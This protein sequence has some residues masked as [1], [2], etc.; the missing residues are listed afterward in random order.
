MSKV[1]VP[2][3][4][5]LHRDM[6]MG[7]HMDSEHALTRLA[8]YADWMPPMVKGFE[9]KAAERGLAVMKES[10]PNDHVER[11]REK[12]FRL[13]DGSMASHALV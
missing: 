11:V 3:R 12:E 2:R 6:L 7:I 8:Q 5:N 9:T 1:H 10:Y 13:A 4:I